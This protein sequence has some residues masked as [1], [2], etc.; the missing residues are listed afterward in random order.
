MTAEDLARGR[1]P[2]DLPR[3]MDDVR[4]HAPDRPGLDDPLLPCG[5][6][7]NDE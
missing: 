4:A 1:L 7:W 6:R 5:Y 2:F 3:S